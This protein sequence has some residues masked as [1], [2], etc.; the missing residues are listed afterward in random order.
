MKQAEQREKI[1]FEKDEKGFFVTST[2]ASGDDT[3]QDNRQ[4][5]RQ[6]ERYYRS[7]KAMRR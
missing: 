7:P 6:K 4:A 3:I 1:Y 2:N 5:K